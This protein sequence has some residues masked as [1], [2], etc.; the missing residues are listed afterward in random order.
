[1][2][3]KTLLAELTPH[4]RELHRPQ[5]GEVGGFAP[6]AP[7]LGGLSN[8]SGYDPQSSLASGSGFASTAI[9][10]EAVR[11]VHETPGGV[12]PQQVYDLFVSGS[13][14]QTLRQHLAQTSVEQ[15]YL[16]TQQRMITLFDPARVWAGAVVRTLSDAT[17]QPVDR[18]H[19]R[20]QGTFKSLATIER[21]SLPRNSDE[22]LRIYHADVPGRS[23]DIASIPLTL[24]ERSDLG[25][26]VVD[27]QMHPSSVDEMLRML[28]TVTASADW[29]CPHLLFLL[30]TGAHWIVTKIERIAWPR[31]I[32][33][34]TISESISSASGVWNKLLGHWQHVCLA[35]AAASP[36]SASPTPSSPLPLSHAP[37]MAS[38]TLPA[39]PAAAHLAQRSAN[40]LS[41]PLTLITPDTPA[42]TPASSDLPE[43]RRT[44]ALIQ[45]LMQVDGLIY[46]A[47]ADVRRGNVFA[48]SGYG[49]DI[50]RAAQAGSDILRAHRDSLRSLGHWKPN[51]PVEEIL[52][53]AGTR[54]HILRVL[55]AHPEYFLLAVLDK[56]RSNLAITRFRVME[57]IQALG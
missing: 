20:D 35:A 47:I 48:G 5:P 37:T 27:H 4:N 29:R 55:P 49:P 30:P 57:T 14:A 12:Q 42:A 13:P 17:G 53:T 25:A 15:A 8:G 45:D 18:M 43:L 32:Q 31:H 9:L 28:Q 36:V 3:L 1:M 50:D 24:M 38:L 23:S 33:I 34:Q 19:V 39:A 16:T 40:T 21:T 52:V 41:A 10:E 11:A 22:L 54:Y 56:L 7:P 51:E 44:E 46:V 6:S 2:L 26:V